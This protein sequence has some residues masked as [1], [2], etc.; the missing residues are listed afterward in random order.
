MNFNSLAYLIYLPIVVVLY[1]ILPFRF[2]WIW[3]LLASYFFY[4]SYSIIFGSLIAITTFVSYFFSLM[5][6]K[7]PKRK[8]LFLIFTITICLG[9]LCVF[10]YLQFAF[11]SVIKVLNLFGLE[12]S[13]FD[14][15]LLLPVGISFYTFQTL[16]YV[17]D[18]YRGDF[19]AECHLGY[20]ALFISF[21]PQLVAG[22]IERPKDLLV[23]LKEEHRFNRDDFFAALRFLALGF[24]RKCCVA[25]V[26][27]IY[28]NN[29]F[30]SLKEANSFTIL[31]AGLMFCFQMY[32]DFAGYSEIA[33]GSARLLGIKLTQ[34]FDKPYSS[35]TYGEFFHRWHRSLNIWFT[36]YLY[37]PLG[38]SRKGKAKKIRNIFIVFTLC[39]LW[40]GARWTYVLWGLYAAIF[41]TFEDLFLNNILNFLKSHHIDT[42]SS[43]FLLL[44]RILIFFIFSIAAILFRAKDVLEAFQAL[45]ILFTKFDNPINMIE[46][47]FEISKLTVP[48]LASVLLFL[49]IMDKGYDFAYHNENLFDKESRNNRISYSGVLMYVAFF[50]CILVCYI[51]LEG[52]DASSA[53]AYFQF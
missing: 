38:G 52:S 15:N 42:K 31:L 26:L 43:G 19:K 8:K 35:L 32:G 12:L 48:L 28:V 2:R 29:I 30:S 21:F 20:Y 13:S 22:P 18:V 6:E 17:I 33:M 23:Q 53:F 51:G 1:Y 40:H 37:I 16:S 34:N 50:L 49:F 47:T 7:Y 27:G 41:I 36:Q 25:D 24:F 5:I 11:E 14:F 44:R 10:K 39:G 4:F 9:I 3:L 45:S 46:K